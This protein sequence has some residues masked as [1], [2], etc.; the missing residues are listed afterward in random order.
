MISEKGVIR[1]FIFYNCNI[2]IKRFD[3]VWLYLLRLFN[4]CNCLISV[5]EEGVF[6]AG[7]GEIPYLI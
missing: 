6:P 5:D 2:S 4:F 1:G 3:I 7:G